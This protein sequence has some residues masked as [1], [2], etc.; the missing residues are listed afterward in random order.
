MYVSWMSTCSTP[1]LGSDRGYTKI[2]NTKC[3]QFKYYETIP[4]FPLNVMWQ[5][6]INQWYVNV[7]I[8][9]NVNRCPHVL[10]NLT[11]NNTWPNKYAHSISHTKG[12]CWNRFINMHWI[13]ELPSI[14]TLYFQFQ[15]LQQLSFLLLIQ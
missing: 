8:P 10:L 9:C 5:Y 11:L 12:Q 2:N 15:W 1:L 4:N 7:I 3:F 14:L 13:C 6:L